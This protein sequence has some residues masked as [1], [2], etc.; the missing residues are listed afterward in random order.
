MDRNTAPVLKSNRS[1][2]YYK[3]EDKPLNK[4]EV[5]PLAATQIATQTENRG[6]LRRSYRVERKFK[7]QRTAVE[8][9]QCLIRAHC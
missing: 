1:S 5:L 9:F 6:E 3:P 2:I 7:G 4:E 8:V